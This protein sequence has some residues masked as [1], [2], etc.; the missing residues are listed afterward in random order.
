MGYVLW[1]GPS[2]LDGQPIVV[3]ITD[4]S[5]N[6][7]TGNMLQSWILRRDLSPLKAVYSHKDESICGDC[8]HRG[9]PNKNYFGRTCYVRVAFAP[10]AIYKSYKAGKYK[11]AP[12]DLSWIKGRKLRLGAY[13]DPAAVPYEVWDSLCVATAGWTGYTHAWRYCDSR[14]SRICMASVDSEEESLEARA[15]GWRTFRILSGSDENIKNEFSC[16]ASK[17]QNKRLSCEQC[18]ACCGTKLGSLSQRA[19]CVSIRAH[20]AVWANL[21]INKRKAKYV[22]S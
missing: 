20:G 6:P 8:Q 18:L 15:A 17:E 11:D 14:F 3:L 1:E 4:N 12:Q 21:T 16:P 22:H 10:E 9:D 5:K 19:G 7:K 13:G 2:Q